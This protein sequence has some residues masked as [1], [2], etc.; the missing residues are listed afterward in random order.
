MSFC[1]FHVFWHGKENDIKEFDLACWV[2]IRAVIAS[3]RQKLHVKMFSTVGRFLAFAHI[4][5]TCMGE[6]KKHPGR[7]FRSVDIES[8]SWTTI[9]EVRQSGVGTKG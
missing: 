6:S 2:P 7:D 9:R 8:S 4:S 5:Q 3:A 1:N